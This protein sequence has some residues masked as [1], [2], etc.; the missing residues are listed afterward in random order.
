METN[1]VPRVCGENPSLPPGEILGLL[2]RGQPTGR[3]VIDE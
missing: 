3:V 1:L 2:M